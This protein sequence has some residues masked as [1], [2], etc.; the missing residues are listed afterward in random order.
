MVNDVNDTLPNSDDMSDTGPSEQDL[1]DA[2]MA[3]SPIMEEIAPPLPEE[4][5]TVQDPEESVEEVEDPEPEEA[6]SEEEEE[7]EEHE[8]EE[9]VEDAGEEPATQ[10][11]EIFTADDLDLDARLSVKVDGEEMEVSFGDLIKGYQTDAHLSKKGRELGEAQKALDEERASKLEEV[12]KL[13]Q[14]NVAMLSQ[15]EQVYAKQYH[16]L[17]SK[18]NKARA[19]GDTYELGELKDKREQVQQQYWGARQRKEQL[20]EAVSKQ[21]EEATS[22]QFEAD[23]ASFQERIPDMIPDFNED[24]AMKIRE[25][26]IEEGI[27]ESLLD[28][29]VDPAVVK[30][31]DDYRR[32]KQGV[33]KG[34]AKRKA[35]PTKKAVPTKKAKPAAK[36]SQDKEKMR[37]ARAFREDAS[38]EDQM[39]FLRDYAS[40][41]LSRI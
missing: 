30:F 6:V 16:D 41:S 26:A 40:K 8:E 2:V 4:E 27:S 28:V 34:A 35:T 22:K 39:D 11:T 9:E 38:P 5:E 15:S 12:E 13:A 23:L 7:V 1:L 32:L 21:R 25:F 19:E 31:V 33:N 29:V 18:I 14:A 17:E 37:K 10:E 24:I 36:K 3:N 20:I